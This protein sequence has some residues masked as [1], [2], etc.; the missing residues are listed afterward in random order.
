LAPTILYLLGESIPGDMDGRIIEEIIQDTFL[1]KNPA[2]HG[3]GGDSDEKTT[4][5]YYDESEQE[6]IRD[7]LK[8]LGYID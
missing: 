5:V 4:S 2:Q 3:S 6:Y 1:L 7:K 8:G